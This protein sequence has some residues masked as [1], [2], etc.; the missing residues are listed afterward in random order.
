MWGFWLCAAAATAAFVL[1]L[2]TPYPLDRVLRVISGVLFVV[3]GFHN[4]RVVAYKRATR[5]PYSTFAPDALVTQ[6][7]TGWSA[8]VLGIVLVGSAFIGL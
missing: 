1:S 8:I 5:G 3:G 7:Q 2:Y 6:R 4:S